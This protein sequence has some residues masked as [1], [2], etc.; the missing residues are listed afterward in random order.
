MRL[1]SGAQ[2]RPKVL[3][4]GDMEAIA[5]ALRWE[6]QAL[7]AQCNRRMVSCYL[8]S[9]HWFW[10]LHIVGP[11]FRVSLELVQCTRSP[12]PEPLG[13]T[14]PKSILSRTF[15]HKW[16][17]SCCCINSYKQGS[18]DDQAV[19]LSTLHDIDQLSLLI[20]ICG[21]KDGWWVRN[22]GWCISSSLSGR[23]L[24]IHNKIRLPHTGSSNSTMY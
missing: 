19:Q 11:D 13:L 21:T 18:R 23:L 10:R 2:W 3:G 20:D 9:P 7:S 8:V 4:N 24:V 1:Q 5:I 12:W 14:C 15:K 22:K 16:C 6:H 17:Q